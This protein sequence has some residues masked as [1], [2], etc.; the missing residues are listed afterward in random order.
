MKTSEMLKDAATDKLA[1]L[2][3]HAAGLPEGTSYAPKL[4]RAVVD[5]LVAAAVA[6][7]REAEKER[8]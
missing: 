1:G 6:E 2:L 3:S 8:T 5:H 4:I 7:I